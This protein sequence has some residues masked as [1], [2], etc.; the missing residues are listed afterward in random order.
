MTIA[1][2]VCTFIYR[3]P[4]IC[5]WLW[6]NLPLTQKDKYLEIRNSIIQSV[7]SREGL[8]LH[9]YN[10]LQMYSYLIAIRLPTAQCTAS[11]FSHHFRLFLSTSQAL[12]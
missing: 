12:I 1:I 8:K 4:L 7:I 3:V 11:C 2:C 5:D 9:A 6:E 10:S